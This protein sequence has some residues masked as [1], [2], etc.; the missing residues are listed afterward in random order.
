MEEFLRDWDLPR[1]AGEGV[2]ASEIAQAEERLGF[3][4][5]AAY[6]EWCRLPFNPFVSEPRLFW[7]HMRWPADLRVWPDEAGEDG[8]VVFKAEYQHC[9]EWAFRVRDAGQEDPPVL[10]GGTEGEMVVDQWRQQ[11][12]TFSGFM[13]QLLMVRSVNFA[14][15]ASACKRIAPEGTWDTIQ[16]QFRSLGFPNWLEYGERC[17]LFGGRDIL[18]LIDSGPP[19]GPAHQ[20]SVNARNIEALEE[21]TNLL[22]FKW[23]RPAVGTWIENFF[24]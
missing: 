22:G 4:L 6:K 18:L 11:S 5:P 19:W 7:T 1:S 12:A 23:D 2:P 8:L 3:R 10:I 20:L 13:L 15:R 16:K 24:E 9:C 21:V 17:Q 14:P